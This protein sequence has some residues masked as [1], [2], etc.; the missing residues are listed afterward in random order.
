MNIRLSDFER[1]L[2]PTIL[3]RGREYFRKGYVTE[4]EDLGHGDYEATVEGSDIYTVSLHVDGDEVT[5]CECDCPYDWGPV[6][7]HVAAVLFYLKND[8]AEKEQTPQ[9]KKQGSPK[10]ESEAVQIEK[11]LQSLTAEDL[12]AFLRDVCFKDK[13]VRRLFLAK[14]V[15][16]LYPESKELYSQQVKELVETYTDRYGGIGYYEAGRLGSAVYEM[17]GEAGREMESGNLRKALYM[18]EAI[19]EGMNEA[20]NCADDS[21]GELSGC[22][23]DAF[24]VLAAL[25]EKAL[26]KPLHDEMFGWLLGHFETKTFKG[27]D[28]H[29]D[30]MQVAISMVGTEEEKSRIRTDLEQIRPS[31]KDWDWDYKRAQDLRLQL[32]RRTEDEASAVRFMEANMDNPDFR[33]ELIE[34]AIDEK[35]YAEAERLA[36][37]GI[38]KDAKNAPGLAADWQNYLLQI[39]L[40]THETEKVMDI[41]RNAFVQGSHRHHPNDYYY[42][43]L[44]SL[45]PQARWP[46]Y[47]DGLIADID[48][49]A[50]FGENYSRVSEIYIWEKQWDK[51]FGLLRKS[52][53]FYRI[54]SAE[55]YL[56]DK[57]PAEL[58]DMYR[59][60]IIEY[61]PDH[62]GRDHYQTVCRYIRRMMKLGQK[63]MAEELVGSLKT[64]YRN[65]RALLEELAHISTAA[66]C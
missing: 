51:L 3:K 19:I 15:S 39:Y 14:Y 52:P 7:K 53:D 45:V 10:K 46:Q 1:Q 61:M 8:L 40:A 32:I 59:R 18:S 66:S 42:K 29:F 44:K 6:C 48:R 35:A 55:K 57:Y 49:N 31:G 37:A 36:K 12:K 26:D 43:L 9:R 38:K 41:A 62:I 25:A 33:K 47:V 54:E 16:R 21:N 27:W 56:A 22:L 17:V 11:L 58:A 4:V 5:D 30:L 13:S 50:L 60:L 63:Q 65:R 64:Q 24:E 23:E 28:W 2:D 20:I 34:R